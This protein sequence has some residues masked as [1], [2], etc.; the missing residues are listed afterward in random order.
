MSGMRQ[1]LILFGVLATACGTVKNDTPD[2]PPP[3]DAPASCP[4]GQTAVCSQNT[5][6]MCDATGAVT[7]TSTC[8]L[9]CNATEPRCNKVNPSNGLA[10]ALD[11]AAQAPDLI[12][13]GMTTIDTDAGTIVD[14]SGARTPPTSTLSA[15][16]PVGVF[17]VKA[18]AIT[19]Q[20]VVVT[21]TK[22]LAIVAGGKVTLNGT[23]SVSGARDISGAGALDTMCRAG[24]GLSGTSGRSGGGGGGFGT[25]GGNGGSGASPTVVGGLGSGPVGNVELVPLRGGCPGGHPGGGTLD[26]D[27]IQSDPGGAGGALQ[28]VSAT[29][30]E[31]ASGGAI[32]A[33]GG[34]GHSHIGILLCLVNTPCGDGE[35]AGSGGGILLEAPI[36]SVAATGG[37]YA[38][39]GGGACQTSGDAASGALGDVPAAGQTCA[40]DTGSGGAGAAASIPAL[41]GANGTGANP[42]GGG[43]GG[44]AGRIRVN[45]PPGVAFAPVGKVS[46]PSSAGVLG[47]R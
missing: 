11:E 18:R 6:T 4:A 28:I 34:G 24:N 15:G 1:T 14:Q 32:A 41:N 3:I 17:V 2:A 40:G 20:N 46:P 37:L 33:N 10:M 47:T 42:V 12:L 9:G 43:G 35:G 31:I 45:L 36:V 26:A 13:M 19:A 44:G 8:P 39:G 25:K 5:L 38:N 16:L 27:P 7:S 30:I 21:G 29:E 22:A 23:F